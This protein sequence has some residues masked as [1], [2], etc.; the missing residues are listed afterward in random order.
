[1]IPLNDYV[2]MR[3]EIERLTELVEDL[4]QKLNSTIKIS[5]NNSLEKG[6]LVYANGVKRFI[7]HENIIMIKAE[8]N[9]SNIFFERGNALFTSKTLKH[10]EE[11]CNVDYVKRVHKSYIINT[12]KIQSFEPKTK[13]IILDENLKA[14]SSRQYKSIIASLT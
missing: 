4:T 7:K 11:R 1:M 3:L 14:F 5:Q 12:N 2:G 10:W 13:T 9:Y 8:G 6:V